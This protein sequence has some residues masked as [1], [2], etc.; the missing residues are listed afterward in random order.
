MNATLTTTELTNR[1]L[2]LNYSRT[3]HSKS[4]N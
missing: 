4:M 3:D 1:W 2:D